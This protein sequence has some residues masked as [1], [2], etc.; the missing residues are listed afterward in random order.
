MSE[1]S[2]AAKFRAEQF[3]LALPTDWRWDANSNLSRMLEAHFKA[4]TAVKDEEIARLTNEVEKSN[5]VE[6]MAVHEKCELEDRVKELEAEIARL[7]EDGELLALVKV[8]ISKLEKEL[9]DF[10]YEHCMEDPETGMMEGGTS[11]QRE[12]IEERE[13]VIARLEATIRAAKGDQN[14]YTKE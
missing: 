2:Q 13:E 5:S 3:R 7:K 11:A 12:W 6:A 9:H 8:E 10:V 1:P 4:A 14:G